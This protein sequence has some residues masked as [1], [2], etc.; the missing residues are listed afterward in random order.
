[1]LL[2]VDLNHVDYRVVLSSSDSGLLVA[3]F[4]RF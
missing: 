1:M 3:R 2:S 4:G